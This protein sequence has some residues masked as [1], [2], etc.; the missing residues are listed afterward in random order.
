MRAVIVKKVGGYELNAG[1]E[2]VESIVE[3]KSTSR[4]VEFDSANADCIHGNVAETFYRV[5]IN[6]L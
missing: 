1:F 2:Y 6:V 3:C 4:C 5:G